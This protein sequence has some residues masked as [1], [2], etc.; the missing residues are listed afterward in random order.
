MWFF[1]ALG[2]SSFAALTAILTKL[3]VRGVN[4]TLA[5]AIQ[6]AV[7]LAVSWAMVLFTGHQGGLA[8]ISRRSWIFLVASGLT[9]GISMLCYYHALQ[10]GAASKVVPVDKLSLVITMVLAFVILHEPISA[11]GMLGCVL[12]VAGALLTSL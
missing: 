1:F 9:S 5:T 2:S 7:V 6:T 8:D 10:I 4:S 11:K 12:M 3:G